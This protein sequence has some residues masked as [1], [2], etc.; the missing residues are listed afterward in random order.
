LNG[1]NEMIART[2]AVENDDVKL[3]YRN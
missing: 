2:L 3:C 1:S